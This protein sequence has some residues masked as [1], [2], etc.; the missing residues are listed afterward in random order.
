M[1]DATYFTAVFRRGLLELGPEQYE[2]VVLIHPG[3]S[4][5]GPPTSRGVPDNQGAPMTYPLRCGT[6]AGSFLEPGKKRDL[7]GDV[8]VDSSKVRLHGQDEISIIITSCGRPQHLSPRFRGSSPILNPCPTQKGDAP[9][10]RRE[11]D[12][13]AGGKRGLSLR[14]PAVESQLAA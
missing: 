4:A 9:R 8:F 10:L 7:T 5:L 13:R 2:C 11:R 12:G 6:S 14:G 1:A 3:A